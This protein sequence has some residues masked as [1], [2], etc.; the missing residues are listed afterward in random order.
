MLG[1]GQ[2]EIAVLTLRL[3]EEVDLSA[4]DL[5]T[6]LLAD[7]DMKNGFVAMQ[8]R[9]P[10]IPNPTSGAGDIELAFPNAEDAIAFLGRLAL[11]DHPRWADIT[12]ERVAEFA[13]KT[14]SEWPDQNHKPER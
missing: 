1:K 3:A 5:L 9:Y 14:R 10:Y 13:E 8:Q 12:H 6:E 7:P 2:Y 4:E 11:S